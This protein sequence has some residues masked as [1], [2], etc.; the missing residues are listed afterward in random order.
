MSEELTKTV[1]VLGLAVAQ[2]LE[3]AEQLEIS[4]VAPRGSL[5]VARNSVEINGLLNEI[6]IVEEILEIL[7]ED[8]TP[9]LVARLR[10]RQA[11]LRT[12]VSEIRSTVS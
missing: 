12:R 3:W 4:G 6:R 2:I 9:L 7:E 11:G 10:E 5:E 1:G 8:D